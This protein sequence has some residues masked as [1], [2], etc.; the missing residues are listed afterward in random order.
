MTADT[1][2]LPI[3]DW[4]GVFS[5]FHTIPYSHNPLHLFRPATSKIKYPDATDMRIKITARKY[6]HEKG[7]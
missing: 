3:V 5:I 2:M 4:F 6:L 1:V 7:M